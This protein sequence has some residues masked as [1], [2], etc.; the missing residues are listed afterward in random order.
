MKLK[1]AT[2]SLLLALV[3]FISGW[4]GLK[5]PYIGSHITLVWLPTGI[6]VAALLHW[7]WR[8]WPGVMLGA[9]LVNLS[10]GSPWAL[11]ASIAV[12]NTLGPLVTALLLQRSGFHTEFDR[13]RDVLYFVGA[14]CS[15]MVL[16]AL[17]GVLNLYWFGLLP[18]TAIA[19]AGLSW[20]MGDTI[21]V[22][23]AAPFC[24]SLTAAS[25]K[26]LNAVRMELL[27][28]SL[29]AGPVAWLAFI[30]DYEQMGRTLPLAFLTLP[31]LAWAALRFGHTG[32]A[33]AGL[34]F[35][36][37]AAWS[38]ATGHGTFFLPNVH[39]SLLLLWAYM[40]TAVL[41]GLLITAL[42]SERQRIE[43]TLRV[44]EDKLN[45]LF[46][47][48][49]LGIALTDMDGHYL[50]FNESFRS[51]CGYSEAELKA[52][53]YWELTPRAYE[54]N[55]LHQIETLVRTGR[56]GPYEKEYIRKDGS[57]V[58]L[59]LNGV[60]VTGR[61]GKR[62]IWSIVEDISEHKRYERT[63]RSAIEVAESANLAKSRFLATMSHEIR[64][65]MNGILGMAQLLMMPGVTDAERKQYASTVLDSGE[66]LLSLLNDILDLS[67]V[68]AGRLELSNGEFM[69]WQVINDVIALFIEPAQSKGL[70][71]EVKLKDVEGRHYSADVVRVRQ[72]LSNLISNAIK[73]TVQGHVRIEVGEL[74][75]D[76]NEAMLE[77]SVTDTGIG[78]APEKLALL[79][80]PF[81]QADSSTTRQYGGTGLGLS[82]VRSLAQLMGGDA[83]VES[84]F[85]EGS[86]F[87]FRI[88]VS[89]LGDEAEAPQAL[90]PSV[91]NAES[92]SA[93]S[94]VARVLVAE[95]NAVNQMVIETMLIKLGY[96]VDTVDN[97][98]K[99][100]DAVLGGSAPD[101]ILMD[102]QMPEVDGLQATSNIRQW[103]AA[104][105]KTH[106]PIIA[107]TASAFAIDKEQCLAAGM[108]DFLPK[109]VSMSALQA[110]L[111]QWLP[112][113]ASNAERPQ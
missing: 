38:T 39:V 30:Q 34:A 58:P 21:G 25:F 62:Y 89:I 71:I 52:L 16:S 36:V 7:G 13:Q 82:I 95:D 84:V 22:L 27:L 88:R 96:A 81:S 51:I 10:I 70:E 74:G 54:N 113:G 17:G 3:Y 20:W 99:A 18:I 49:P 83:G 86:R 107:L 14:S 2:Y 61:D 26:R 63:L 1:V 31:L 46:E 67:K 19:T 64:T 28:W 77:F 37:V 93:P 33:L 87:W 110:A 12:G 60:L 98:Q 92:A 41:T 111:E 56:Y 79:F 75:L 78:V 8:L 108:D 103:E 53:D 112:R 40:A 90:S 109:P 94:R 102:V 100:V 48:S 50:E 101:L 76:G 24:L 68:E 69:P 9:F 55:E 97:G 6:A 91:E 65:P 47:L 80:K 66:T 44:S 32:S 42:Q 4:L 29:I 73:F 104:A 105:R 59:R 43:S 45:G 15:G 23:L 57:H 72:M 106:L 11:A 85:G 5:I 35:A